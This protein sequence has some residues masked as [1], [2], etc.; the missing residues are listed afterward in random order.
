MN[1]K[2]KATILIVEDDPMQSMMYETQFTNDGYNVITAN[3]EAT[4]LEQVQKKPD[5]VFLDLLLGNSDG[6]EI[7]KKIKKDT[8]TKN[9]KVVILSNFQ[10]KGLKSQCKRAGALDFLVKS[11]FIPK[12]VEEIAKKYIK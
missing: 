12:E 4:A 9:L 11:S 7:L 1:A 3:D 10:K 2:K 5:L 6:I 8:K